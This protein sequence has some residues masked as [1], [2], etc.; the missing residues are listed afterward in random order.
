MFRRQIEEIAHARE[1]GRV[2]QLTTFFIG[3]KDAFQAKKKKMRLLLS[4]LEGR[5]ISAQT[6][7]DKFNLDDDSSDFVISSNSSS[8]DNNSVSEAIDN[9]TSV[10]NSIRRSTDKI[11]SLKQSLK[12]TVNKKEF[13]KE[14]SKFYVYKHEM[15]NPLNSD[16]NEFEGGDDQSDK[17]RKRKK[18]I[19]RKKVKESKEQKNKDITLEIQMSLK[20][21][22]KAKKITD[23]YSK[24][25]QNLEKNMPKKMSL[26]T[27]CRIDAEMKGIQ[28]HKNI[29]TMIAETLE[30]NK[31][32][33]NQDILESHEE[34]LKIDLS[35]QKE[36]NNV[37]EE[38]YEKVKNPRPQRLIPVQE[39]SER[40]SDEDEETPQN[41]VEDQEEEGVLFNQ[42]YLKNKGPK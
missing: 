36:Y 22:L 26:A 16:D 34:R 7:E 30:N 5:P 29:I 10:K 33:Q 39:V 28:M 41:K 12:Q 35:K 31:I 40:S 11:K 1:E 4:Q 42:K 3:D 38:V 18:R 20:L 17:P 6:E 21:M 14:K 9:N 15:T 25:F 32:K 8:E 23:E 27:K 37:L 13:K 2:K 19:L 24:I